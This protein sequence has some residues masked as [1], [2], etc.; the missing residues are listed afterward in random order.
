MGQRIGQ[1]LDHR[2]VDFG[3]FANG[4]ELDLLGGLGRQFAH[5]AR[6]AAE[7]R[8]DRLGAD[9]HDRVLE[10]A[11]GL[12]QNFKAADQLGIAG[13]QGLIHLL[14][15][16]GLGD[17][18]FAHHVD[19]AVHLVEIDADRLHADGA[20]TALFAVAGSGRRRLGG[21]D[22]G[23]LGLGGCS[24]RLGLDLV[25]QRRKAQRRGF[26]EGVLGADGRSRRLGREAW[27]RHDRRS[28]LGHFLFGEGQEA[29]EVRHVGLGRFGSLGLGNV[30]SCA[31]KTRDR[32]GLGD[33][34]VAVAIDELEDLADRRLGEAGRD[35]RDFPGAIDGEGLEI[36]QRRHFAQ[37]GAHL[38]RAQGRQLTEQQQRIIGAGIKGA[39]R[40]EADFPLALGRRHGGSVEHVL[41]RGFAGRHGI[42]IDHDR[43]KIDV[44]LL[45]DLAAHLVVFRRGFATGQ[46]VEARLLLGAVIGRQG[47]ARLGGIDVVGDDV[48]GADAQ[49]HHVVGE[50]DAAI[51]HIVEQGF[52]G[53]GKAHQR[54]KTEGPGAALD[55]VDGAEH[56]V[57]PVRAALALLDG[58]KLLFELGQKL[59]TF[60]EIG[61]LEVVEITHAYAPTLLGPI[62]VLVHDAV[63]DR[64]ELFRVEGLDDPAGAAGGLALVTLVLAGFGREDQDGQGIVLAGGAHI[65]DELDAVHDRHVDVGDD[66]VDIL[67]PEHV[68]ALLA[69]LG[70]QHLEP[71]IA[72]RMVEHGQD[73]ARIIDSQYAQRHFIIP[74]NWAV[75]PSRSIAAFMAAL[76]ASIVKS[77]W[78]LRAVSAALT[79]RRSALVDTL[80]TAPAWT[81]TGPSSSASIKASRIPSMASRS[82]T[83][84]KATV[85]LDCLAM[86]LWVP[87]ESSPESIFSPN[88]L[89][90]ANYDPSA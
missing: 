64:D 5:Q 34:D 81:A 83:S 66:H 19:D 56:R 9:G 63:D 57:E 84:G 48:I 71:G 85:C 46:G 38:H 32:A 25:G 77:N 60:I 37:D 17:D 11:R 47:F 21:C 7:D 4:L 69:I 50:F 54:R 79:N 43:G 58:G 41:D 8:F 13:A 28:G 30:K 23:R 53:M 73:G 35:Q 44:E 72:Q 68:Q 62:L 29:R 52:I 86:F 22:R 1:L 49:N 80:S 89:R 90:I 31:G 40:G 55:R 12:G 18:Q 78:C 88:G 3:V 36:G 33:D 75:R 42:E 10:A 65:L 2:L 27:R 14:G 51:A 67:R 87:P 74:E 39:M 61:G 26:L 15:Q 45:D 16:H 70:L 24:R 76:G 20:A 6:H 59:R 82:I